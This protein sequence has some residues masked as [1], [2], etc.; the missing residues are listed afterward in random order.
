MVIQQNSKLH[1]LIRYVG[2]PLALLLVWDIAVTIGYVA[3]NQTTGIDFPSL[4]VTL[5]GS[6]LVLFLS[7]RN[8]AA[9]ARWWEART[10]WGTVVN[11]S[12]TFA[13]QASTMVDSRRD[14]VCTQ[15]LR[16]N[17]IIRQIT[18]ARAL[19][20]HLLKQRP[21]NM[22]EDLSHDERR[23]LLQHANIPNAILMYNARDMTHA[24]QSGVLGNYERVAMEQTLV[25]LSDAQGGL[26]R[27]CNTPLPKQYAQYPRLFVA[28]FCVLL[29]LGLVDSLWV[30]TPLASTVVGF[31]L[32]TMEKMGRDLQDP[33]NNDVHDV[34][35]ESICQTIRIDLLQCIGKKAPTPLKS[36]NGVLW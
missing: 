23:E 2:W 34:P 4:P 18:Y 17:M 20:Y 26:E 30:Y 24:C 12:R 22:L 25:A 33:F 6:A 16:H 10:L 3:L 29:P 35:M 11:Y 7:L 15:S 8:N 9:Y 31:M 36:V 28:V 19:R 14:D 32:M 27:I 5:T 1:S 21:E 13:R